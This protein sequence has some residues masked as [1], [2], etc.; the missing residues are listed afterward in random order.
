M[1]TFLRKYVGLLALMLVPA[2]SRAEHHWTPTGSMALS[3]ED[4]TATLL[5]SGKV[6]VAGGFHSGWYQ[7]RINSAEVYD[8]EGVAFDPATGTTT[9]GTWSDTG[10]LLW[11][12]AYHA[13]VLLCATPC[14][15]PTAE[16][17]VV[18]G[19]GAMGSGNGAQ[20]VAELYDPVAGTWSPTGSMVTGRISPTATRLLSGKVLVVGGQGPDAGFLASAELYDPVAGTWSSAGTSG[21]LRYGHTAT[22]LPS[23]KVLV[24]GGLTFNG[25]GSAEVYDPE[26]VAFD[27]ATG[28]TTTGTWSG[29]G[30]MAIQQRAFHTATLLCAATPCLDPTAKVLTAGGIGGSSELYDPATRIWTVT[31]P[32]KIGRTGH[33]ATLLPNGK[34]VLV[35][36]GDGYPDT[37]A[38][39]EVYR[40]TWS[41]TGPLGTA[42]TNHTATL[43][44]SGKVLVAGGMDRGLILATAELY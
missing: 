41:T 28:T 35:A 2:V 27:P 4:H 29:T 38:S 24:A 14:L 31:D 39:V 10:P 33:T 25:N 30:L 18:G 9:T 22:L 16:V 6:L 19:Q 40:Q 11:Y 20:A 12:S 23:G 17:L 37:L 34:E 8:P 43:L 26:G 1:Q 36:G 3:R 13:A 7:P 32:M 42:R 5:G 15:D 44:P 21:D